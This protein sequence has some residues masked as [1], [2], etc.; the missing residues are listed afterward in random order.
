MTERTFYTDKSDTSPLPIGE[1]QKTKSE[2]P[3]SILIDG[4]HI[5][6]PPALE[7][8]T[9]KARTWTTAKGAEWLKV[10]NDYK[11]LGVS[12]IEH[13]SDEYHKVIVEPLLPQ[14]LYV[15]T[16]ALAGSIM[17]RRRSLITRMLAPTLLGLVTFGIVMPK[18][19][20]NCGK[21]TGEFEAEHFPD[22]KKHQDDI[23]AQVKK[24]NDK[25]KSQ[26]EKIEPAITEKVKETRESILKLLGK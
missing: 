1:K 16:A 8:Y 18:S 2:S 12:K 23:V 4:K 26:Y 20:S 24:G 6:A 7:S 3:N 25:V 11:S 13:A 14:S 9:Q 10:F 21:K 22:V 17:T 19:F 5:D 15:I